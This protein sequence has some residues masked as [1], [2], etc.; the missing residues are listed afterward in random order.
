MHINGFPQDT[1]TK[2]MLIWLGDDYITQVVKE[3]EQGLIRQDAGSQVVEVECLGDPRFE[4][5]FRRKGD[6][7]NVGVA[8]RMNVE[9]DIRV[10]VIDSQFRCW[11][12][13]L[14]AQYLATSLDDP[15]NTKIKGNFQLERDEPA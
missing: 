3:L 11:N 9:F 13:Y 1:D 8:T 2:R 5:A 12:L 10:Q 14:T 4:T 6:N 7:P 15:P